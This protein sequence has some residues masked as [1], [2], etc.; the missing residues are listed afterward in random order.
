[1]PK[2]LDVKNLGLMV[3]SEQQLQ[4]QCQELGIEADGSR[5]QL[6]KRILE[7]DTDEEEFSSLNRYDNEAENE[8]ENDEEQ[9]RVVTR[10]RNDIRFDDIKSCFTKF[11]GDKFS[12]VNVWI[13]HFERQCK[14]YGLSLLQRFAFA[15]RLFTDT[16]KLFVEYE[17]TA[18]CWKEL[19]FELINEYGAKTDS[20]IIHTRLGERKKNKDES[21]IQYMYV[22]LGIAKQG[23]VDE[24]SI[25]RYVI[26]GL[27]GNA[28]NKSFMYEARSIYMLKQKLETYEYV[29]PK[30]ENDGRTDK[31][32][33]VV[34]KTTEGDSKNYSA[35]KIHCFSCGD[36]SHTSN[37]CP[38]K[39]KGPK[40][41]SC[42]EFGH[43]SVDCKNKVKKDVPA[44]V[45]IM[46][47]KHNVYLN[48]VVN[49]VVLN[50]LFDT[51]SDITAI[52][53][54]VARSKD[55]KYEKNFQLIHGVGGKTGTKGKLTANIRICDN[56]FSSICHIVPNVNID[57]EMII[58]LDIISQGVLSVDG[59][60]VKFSKATAKTESDD[61]IDSH[62][63]DLMQI[64]Y[65]SNSELILPDLSHI[66]KKTTIQHIRSMI[67][68]YD[69]KPVNKPPV[70]LEIILKDDTP[71]FC[72]PKRL[73]I[74][75][76]NEVDKQMNQWLKDGI[77]QLSNSDFASRV[78][79]APKKDST[80]RLCIDYRAL[81]KK[82]IKDRYPLPNIEDQLDKLQSGKIFSTL[83]LTNGFFHV[84]VKEN[85]RKFT[86]FVTQSGQ[87]EF[88]RVP[89][90]LCVS[91]PV[92]Q[93]FINMIFRPLMEQNIVLTY[94]DDLIIVAEEE[95]EAI[96]RLQM[97]LDLA[98]SYNL[99]IK[100]QKC[101]FLQTNILFLGH[102]IENGRIKPSPVKS[103]DVQRFSEPKNIKEVQRF[104]GLTGYMRKFIGGYASIAKPLS[105]LLRNEAT[106]RFGDE[107]RLAFD[108]LKQ[109]ISEKPVLMI[110]CQGAETQVHTDA[111]KDAYGAIL[112]QRCFEDGQFHPVYYMSTKTS[113]NEAK[114]HSY[115]LEV[116]AVVKAVQK[117]RVYLLGSPFVVITDCKAF[118]TTMDKKDIPKIARWA[119]I[120]QEYEFEVQHRAG[121]SMKHVDALSRMFFIE[122]PSVRHSL[123]KSQ[124]N[125][126]SIKA[127][128]AIIQEK[129][130]ENY[131]MYN[132][133]LCKEIEG[134]MLIVVPELMQMNIV[135]RSHDQGHFKY[136]KLEAMIAKEFF[137]P[138][139]QAKVKDVVDNCVECIL[140]ERKSGKPEGK[141]HPIAKEP[142]PL[143]TF[144]IDH[145][146][147]MTS[148]GRQY[149]HILA[150]IDA[151]TKFV[152]LFPV[153]STTAA[154]TLN[155]LRL[156][157]NVFG[158]PRRIITDKGSAFTSNDFRDFCKDENIELVLCTTGVPRGNGQIERINRIIIAVLGK[159][160]I[161]NT[162][163]W[164]VHLIDVQKYLNKSFQRAI[165]M[166]PFELMIG[167]Q[168][169]TKND[170]KISEIIDEEVTN[171]FLVQRDELRQA[172]KQQ[173]DKVTEENRRTYNANR[174]EATKYKIGD[175]VSIARTQFGTGMKL[176]A[177]NY[178]PYRVIKVKGN[179]RYDVEKVGDHEGPGKTN[180]S[181]DNMKK[182][183]SEGR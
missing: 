162:E 38:H 39:E 166:T 86:S 17:S 108:T 57:A 67:S 41:F 75:E 63:D 15:H 160:S 10:R 54:D 62:E 59:K 58:G 44:K 120:L 117:F 178:G 66:S 138:Q 153:K 129:P 165:K 30:F 155:K 80:K 2:T 71:V 87:F 88:L 177:K 12:D 116:I 124:A 18:S 114:L 109:K 45:N 77:I 42:N 163:K 69:P 24:A 107:Q 5:E 79:L 1:M 93:R 27:P 16:A 53:E 60:G 22:M 28:A 102:E 105:D 144:H 159:M 29:S 96:H 154:E 40:C 106:F 13:S 161:D 31:K 52:R 4:K 9:S 19:K 167:V 32:E 136:T 76:R 176:S 98:A 7:H 122:I 171:E 110:F 84:S 21:V 94:M 89:F 169:K 33:R 149:N 172:A 111:S 157:T 174:K 97:V 70:E 83:D 26:D 8:A 46:R 78:V 119:M 130:Y 175:L 49:G 64:L 143:D 125:D 115:E 35:K 37:S 100:W 25:V 164:Y 150:I 81:N 92:F 180:T 85:S 36:S 173:I 65:I 147:P 68:N 179:D 148:T 183:P 104:L 168:M 135:R 134:N 152:W 99:Q 131:T 145:L 140:I 48:V 47:R 146:G 158:N 61:A 95:K 3:L 23:N 132:G 128:K 182:W 181:V 123:M 126:E 74:C 101:A 137:I 55:I 50:A 56:E 156:V 6:I 73:P 133:L 127:I 141:L 14:T 51:G 11:N 112:F 82:I 34:K 118:A 121:T 113:V 90:G 20:I 142:L 91:P 170:A 43:K 72:A 139:L 151:F 103:R